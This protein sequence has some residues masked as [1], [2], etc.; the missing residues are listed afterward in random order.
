MSLRM[1][2]PPPHGGK[3]VERV[4]RDRTKAESLVAGC[5]TFDI[6]PTMDGATPIR[7]V[8]REIMS[9]C[10]GLLSPVEGT[11]RKDEL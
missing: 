3:L 8:Y 6:K 2:I 9:T 5:P 1:N 7:N 11:M 4:V 10:Y